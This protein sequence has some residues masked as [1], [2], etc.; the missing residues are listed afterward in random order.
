MIA[1]W[2][3]WERVCWAGCSE[4][5]RLQRSGLTICWKASKTGVDSTG[6]LF[7]HLFIH[8]FSMYFIFR[9]ANGGWVAHYLV[10]ICFYAG[11]S[12]FHFIAKRRKL[13]Q[14]RVQK[15]AEMLLPITGAHQ[16]PGLFA[17]SDLSCFVNNDPCPTHNGEQT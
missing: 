4:W 6:D 3:C 15:R 7:I 5:H 11:F 16:N 12:L 8:S 9:L 17:I 10:E 14:K 1:G 13:L 2:Q